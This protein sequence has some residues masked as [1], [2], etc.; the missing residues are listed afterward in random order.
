M[1]TQKRSVE[2]EL[3]AFL[4]HVLHEVD[5]WF[6]TSTAQPWLRSGNRIR[7]CV[8]RRGSLNS[9][10][11]ENLRVT[12]PGMEIKPQISCPVIIPSYSALHVDIL[13][14]NKWYF[15]VKFFPLQANIKKVSSPSLP[16]PST[17]PPT[18]ECRIFPS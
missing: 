14:M 7:V 2:V 15:Y 13:A 6:H 17:H 11:K 1:Q 5:N 16:P 8:D 18:H 4:I 3:H 10:M 9:M 12:L